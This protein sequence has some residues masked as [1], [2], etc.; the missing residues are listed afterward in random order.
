MNLARDAWFS[1]LGETLGAG[2]RTDIDAYCA[3]LGIEQSGAP[4]LV[5]TWEDAAGY[6]KKPAGPWWAKEEAERA[7]LEKTIQLSPSD[8]DW[9]KLNDVLQGCAAIAASRFGYSNPGMIKVAAGSA[10]FAAYHE[11]LADGAKLAPMHPFHRKYSL[12]AAGR[13]P[14]GVYDGR[15]VIF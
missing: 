2:E 10:S 8:P 9:I 13:W 6:V 5:T 4:L 12:F 11:L 14:L 3:G 1:S 15:F 7:N